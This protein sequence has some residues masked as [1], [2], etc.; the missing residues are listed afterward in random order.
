MVAVKYSTRLV[1]RQLHRHTLGHAGIHHVADRSPAEVVA[2]HPGQVLGR[3]TV[4]P[5]SADQARCR[6]STSPRPVQPG[7]G[8]LTAKISVRVG[9]ERKSLERAVTTLGLARRALAG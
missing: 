6:A 7:D 1:A 9:T 5:R 4:T 2:I 3:I 8:L